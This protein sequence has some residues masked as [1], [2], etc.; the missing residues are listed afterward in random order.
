MTSCQ[1]PIA[2]IVIRWVLNLRP[3]ISSYGLKS[4]V[5]NNFPKWLKSYTLHHIKTVSWLDFN[6]QGPFVINRHEEFLRVGEY[7]YAVLRG[8]ICAILCSELKE[9]KVFAMQAVFLITSRAV[10]HAIEAR[11][12]VDYLGLD[13]GKISLKAAPGLCALSKLVNTS[14]LLSLVSHGWNGV[15]EL[16][17]VLSLAS[18]SWESPFCEIDKNVI[19]RDNHW[20]KVDT[21]PC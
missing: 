10:V 2:V 15:F 17:C 7:F 5:S 1:L 12:D 20:L 9:F 21:R 4:I 11:N 3:L 16:V 6:F 8:I 13:A 18:L 14:N 19:R